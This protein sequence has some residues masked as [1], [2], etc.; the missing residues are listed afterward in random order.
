[1]SQ[2]VKTI[3]DRQHLVTL[4]DSDPDG[5]TYGSVHAGARSSH[6]QEGYVDIALLMKGDR[7]TKCVGVG[8]GVQE[9]HTFDSGRCT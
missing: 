8:G 4:Q 1:M 6:V 5:R 9:P 2:A 7:Q 3:V